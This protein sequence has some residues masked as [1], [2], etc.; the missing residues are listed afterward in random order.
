MRWATDAMG[1]SG[2]FG[3][4]AECAVVAVLGALTLSA[5]GAGGAAARA[6]ERAAAGEIVAARTATTKT[7]RNPDGSYTKRLFAGP[8]HYR[9]G[10]AWQEIRTRVIPVWQSLGAA[11]ATA[12][13][14]GDYTLRNQAG[15][16]GAMFKAHPG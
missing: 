12:P 13:A 14:A 9:D 6:D 10:G 16:F 5:G 4:G 3:V 11:Q 8:V 2:R 15:A 1:W 7:F